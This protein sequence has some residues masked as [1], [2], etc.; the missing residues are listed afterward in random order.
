MNLNVRFE[1]AEFK[2]EINN[3]FT[4]VS[5]MQEVV[6]RILQHKKELVPGSLAYEETDRAYSR[7]LNEYLSQLDERS[8]RLAKIA[9]FD[10]SFEFDLEY[11][12][13]QESN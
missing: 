4:W 7:F 6:D 9:G 1:S 3:W 11:E 13:F 10:S 2:S 8:D 5:F 12:K